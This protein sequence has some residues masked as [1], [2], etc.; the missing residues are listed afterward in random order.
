MEKKAIE[1]VEIKIAKLIRT[2]QLTAEDIR[3]SLDEEAGGI[4][5]TAVYKNSRSIVPDYLSETQKLQRNRILLCSGIVLAEGIPQNLIVRKTL[6]AES[7]ALVAEAVHRCNAW[8]KRILKETPNGLSINYS[9]IDKKYVE[10]HDGFQN[11]NDLFRGTYPEIALAL[12]LIDRH[13]AFVRWIKPVAN[14]H[15]PSQPFYTET[16]RC[17]SLY[18]H[19]F[20][21]PILSMSRCFRDKV[22][23]SSIYSVDIKAEEIGIAGAL[24]GDESLMNIYQSDDVYTSFTTEVG[25]DISRDIAKIILLGATKGMTPYG[26]AINAGISIQEATHLLKKTM[27]KFE[28]YRR[29]ANRETGLL[30]DNRG[31]VIGR[32]EYHYLETILGVNNRDTLNSKLF[33]ARM[34]SARSFRVQANASVLLYMILTKAVR[35][36]LQVVGTLHDA[37]YVRGMSDALR[38]QEIIRECSVL[39]FKGFELKSEIEQCGM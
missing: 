22:I 38:L 3:A 11:V 27:S 39:L 7:E 18:N 2:G 24:S 5:E 15:N 33:E 32:T 30:L 12:K 13:N 21:G 35:E 6:I 17:Q 23:D 34:N 29:W 28:T 4:I 1:H 26:I 10:M 36:S 31:K 8:N 16:G 37:V 14:I 9:A 19:D 25:L 20:D